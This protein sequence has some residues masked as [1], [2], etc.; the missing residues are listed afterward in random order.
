MRS[1][2]PGFFHCSTRRTH[3]ALFRSATSVSNARAAAPLSNDVVDSSVTASTSPAGSAKRAFTSESAREDS[4]SSGAPPCAL[5][6]DMTPG[7]SHEAATAAAIQTAS[8]IARRAGI[9]R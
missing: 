3:F 5:S 9:A 6:A 4:A 1:L 7:A 8:V 2:L